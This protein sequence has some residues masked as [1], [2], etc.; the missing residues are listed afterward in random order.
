MT[1]IT[2]IRNTISAVLIIASG[3]L[4]ILN[5]IAFWKRHIRNEPNSPSWIPLLGALFGALS[6]WIA[7]IK[8][9]T[10]WWIPLFIDWGSLPGLSYTLFWHYRRI[11][12]ERKK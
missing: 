6:L 2:L 7:P 1:N 3:Y 11:K 4:I 9:N 10:L 5:W 8:L 12:S